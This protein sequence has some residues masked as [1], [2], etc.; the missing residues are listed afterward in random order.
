MDDL[1]P[2]SEG[3]GGPKRASGGVGMYSRMMKIEDTIPLYRMQTFVRKRTLTVQYGIKAKK[4]E[5]RLPTSPPH[6]CLLSHLAL[7]PNITFIFN[8]KSE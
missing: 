8:S 4:T 1:T 2:P 5:T 6:T 7:S 3:V